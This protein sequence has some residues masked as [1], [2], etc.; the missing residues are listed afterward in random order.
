MQKLSKKQFDMWTFVTAWTS[1]AYTLVL[2]DFVLLDEISLLVEFNVECWNNATLNINST[3][4][5]DIK[6]SSWDNIEA[7][8]LK[9]T[10][11]YTLT[12]DSTSDAFIVSET[13]DSQVEEIVTTTISVNGTSPIIPV[14]PNIINTSAVDSVKFDWT[15]Y[16][17]IDTPSIKKFDIWYN[18]IGTYTYTSAIWGFVLDNWYLYTINDTDNL[19]LKIDATTMT[20]SDSYTNATIKPQL[21]KCGNYLVFSL[22]GDFLW[23][24]DITTF[25]YVDASAGALAD[26]NYRLDSD[27]TYVYCRS[28]INT[29]IV[30]VDISSWTA[31]DNTWTALA[32]YNHQYMDGYVYYNYV[33]NLVRADVATMTNSASLYNDMNNNFTVYGWYV[34][35]MHDASSTDDGELIKIKPANTI[36]WRLPYV[37]I[38]PGWLIVW[39]ANWKLF[40]KANHAGISTWLLV[41]NL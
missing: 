7:G 13:V 1:T 5:K 17:V 40:V 41:I 11:R 23:K 24:L 16:Y 27:G 2:L 10:G 36:V 29:S 15:Y 26:Q 3:G 33:N 28:D 37:Y 12:Y 39:S 14:I 18:L 6:T 20:L 34:Y 35:V 8:D 22:N 21:T 4:A 19:L 9:A 31:L 38:W 30:K 32:T 25:T